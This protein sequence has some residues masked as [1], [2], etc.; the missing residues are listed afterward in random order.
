MLGVWRST[1]LFP[2]P[3]FLLQTQTC[4]YLPVTSWIQSKP[5]EAGETPSPAD[6]AILPPWSPHDCP[7]KWW[8]VRPGSTGA[9]QHWA[10][11]CVWTGRRGSSTCWRSVWTTPGSTAVCSWVWSPCAASCSPPSREDHADERCQVS[12]AVGS[13]A[14]VTSRP[15]SR[16][17][18]CWRPTGTEEWRRP[19]PLASSSSSSQGTWPT[20]WAAT[21]P[22]SCPFR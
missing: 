18:R 22:G 11:H 20:S 4:W 16:A 5:A 9:L 1:H 14:C 13:P 7:A 15:F 21:S 6:W 8:P 17:G 12:G 19:C 2:L 3:R 10:G